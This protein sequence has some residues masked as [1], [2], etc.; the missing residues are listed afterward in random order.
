M[1]AISSMIRSAAVGLVA[2]AGYAAA[3]MSG[4]QAQA[5]GIAAS[6]PGS[7]YHSSASAI[8]KVV[9][10]HAGLQATVQP[11]ASPTVYLPA[12]AAG[13]YAFAL[14]NVEELRV[15]VLGDR[16]YEGRKYDDLRSVAIMYPLRNGVF[17]R[18]DSDIRSMADLKGKRMTTGFTSQQTIPPIIDAV[19]ATAGLTQ[20]DVVAVQ[21]PNVVAG[22]NAFIEGKADAF[23]FAHGSAKVSEADAAVGGVRSLPIPYTPE[24]EATIQRYFPPAYLREETAG[25]NNPG[26]T[27]PIHVLTYDAVVAASSH[28]PED[29]VYRLAKAM[30]E[31]KAGMAEVFPVFNF[32]DPNRMMSDLGPV[33]WHE[34]AVRFY[35]EQGLMPDGM[36]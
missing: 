9:N 1:I 35:K 14:T 8:A 2:F 7:L 18:A 25:R 31:N 3:S 30:H 29:V 11:F 19:L 24:N 4:A 16:W 28:T 34:G 36:N 27:E 15:A 22:A 17:V 26:V 5:V 13:E 32:F 23:I 10:D 6:N 12:V 20:D 21:V 33:Q